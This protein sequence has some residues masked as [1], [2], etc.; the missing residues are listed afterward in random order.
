MSLEGMAQAARTLSYKMRQQ[1]VLS[2]NLANAGTDAFK[3][4][5]LAAAMLPGAADAVPVEQ[6]DLSQGSFRETGRP[7]DLGIE[8]PGFFV[9]RTETGERLIRG[10]SFRLDGAARLTDL[11][12]NPL[13]STDGEIAIHGHAIEVGGDGT[14][15]VDGALVG[16]LRVVTVEDR[17]T[18]LKEGHG[19]YMSEAP[20]QEVQVDEATIRQGV[21]EEAN[22][23][24]ILSMVDL[25]SIQRAYAANVEALRAMDHV[26]DVITSDVGQA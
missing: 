14:I 23:D 17:S 15:H 24:P 8:G 10:G 1:E 3:A 12:G 11:H 18:L 9:V 16:R 7:L 5:R 6:I 26:L 25:I 20:F 22:V 4:V 2:N 21:I 13:L 19:R